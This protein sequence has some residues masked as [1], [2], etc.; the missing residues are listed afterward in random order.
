MALYDNWR[1]RV[2]NHFVGTNCNYSRIFE[3][4]ETNKVP[5]V[6][7]DLRTTYVPDLPHVDWQWISTHIWA[8]T[9]NFLSDAQLTR[10]MALVGGEEFNGL[11]YWRALHAENVGGSTQ[12]ANLERGHFIAFPRC[13][14]LAHLEPHLKQWIQLKNKFGRELPEDHLIGMFGQVIPEALKEEIKNQRHLTGNLPAQISWVFTEIAERTDDKLSRWNLAKLQG[15]LKPQTRNTTGIHNVNANGQDEASAAAAPPPVPD[16]ATFTATM[17]RSMEKMVA[18]A[19]TRTGRPATRTSP[20][21]RSGSNDSNRSGRRIPSASFK[22]CWCC[23]SDKHKRGD[24]PE[25]KSIKDKNGGKC[26]KNNAGAWEKSSKPKPNI[27]AAIGVTS[28]KDD[29]ST[30]EHSET[31]PLW[32]VLAMPPPPTTH[33]KFGSLC[34][35]ADSDDD[36]E[37]EVMKALAAITPN[38]SRASDH[39]SQRNRKSRSQ[40]PLNIG[41]LNAVARDVKSGKI[42]LPDADLSS[43]SDFEYVWALV[44]SGA[45]ANVAK[46]SAF[47]ESEPTSA[48]TITL[49]TANGEPLHHA[50]AHRVTSY[51][52]DGA[53]VRRVFYDANVE[54]P[55]LAV[56]ELSKEGLTGSDVRLQQR[57]GYIRDLTTGKRQQIV[58]R[59]GVY[60][61][62]M[63]IRKHGRHTIDSGFARPVLP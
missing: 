43:N 41:H 37:S 58:K 1:L 38:I 53:P 24:C 39:T 23:G 62:K 25:F 15:Q 10:R 3:L 48:P 2:R 33:N 32:P 17:E 47:T 35:D 21:S 14:N 29:W 7:A 6:W 50:G 9:G 20:G 36:D 8:F 22:G 44:D 12:L 18:A 63:Y 54:M 34:D 51:T 4:V 56:S 59:R 40:K 5:I 31:V 45:G 55:I 57:G 11:E 27:T 49:S 28:D 13:D 42:A 26:P 19:M 16:M 30:V 46:R 52:Q 60:F 61:T